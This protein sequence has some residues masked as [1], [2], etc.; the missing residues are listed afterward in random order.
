MSG[1]TSGFRCASLRRRTSCPSRCLPAK[2]SDVMDM[3]A[4]TITITKAPRPGQQSVARGQTIRLHILRHNPADP[5]SVP[6]MQTYE[7]EQTDGM[8]LFIALT[9]LRETQD[10]SLQ[11]DF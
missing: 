1:S 5:S 8:T 9:E 6:H 3:T 10:P 2:A 11:L 7:L 4:K